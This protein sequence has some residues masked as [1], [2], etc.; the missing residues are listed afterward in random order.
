MDMKDS[1]G[2]SLWYWWELIAV[3]KVR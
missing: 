3:L 2:Q 1:P